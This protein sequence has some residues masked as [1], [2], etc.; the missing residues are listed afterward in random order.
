MKMIKKVLYGL[1]ILLA[2]LFIIFTI[3]D[4][5]KYNA[6]YSAPFSAYILVR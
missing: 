4:L 2:V 1:A 6:S 5:S 3:I